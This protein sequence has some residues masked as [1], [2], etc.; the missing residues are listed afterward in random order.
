MVGRRGIYRGSRWAV[1]QIPVLCS[2]P[3]TRRDDVQWHWQTPIR[4]RARVR[5]RPARHGWPRPR[6]CGD[7]GDMT[8]SADWQNFAVMTGGASGALTGLL[9]V[10]V[11]L[12]ASRRHYH[13]CHP[14]GLRLPGR[15]PARERAAPCRNRLQRHENRLT[16]AA[17]LVKSACGQS[18]AGQACQAR[19]RSRARTG[20]GSASRARLAAGPASSTCSTGGT[21]SM[22]P[23]SSWL[24]WR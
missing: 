1:S 24:A 21:R 3:G 10:S 11:S 6:R 20:L 7:Y 4:R 14:A 23:A 22:R 19:A 15:L 9:F 16:Q 8:P 12:N 18:T 13:P 2:S 5:A 17:H